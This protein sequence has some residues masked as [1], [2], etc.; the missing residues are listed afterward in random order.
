MDRIPELPAVAD[1]L[2]HT[3]SAVLLDVVLE[4]NTKVTVCAADP[5]RA[6]AYALSD[7]TIPAWVGLE[8]LAQG[9]AA[10]AG[11]EAR[12]RGE[13]P[14]LGLFLGSR[15]IVIHADALPSGRRLLVRVE[16][17]L[18]REGPVSFACSLIDA[19]TLVPLMEGHLTALAVRD[20]SL[21]PGGAAT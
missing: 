3:G 21:I 18:G 10:H 14:S 13:P 1:V 8:L 16:H 20:P 11:L 19:D 2:P 12:V 5:A 15:R 6:T 9:V 17:R 4:H 7:G